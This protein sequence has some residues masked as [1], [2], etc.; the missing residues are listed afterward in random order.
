MRLLYRFQE[1]VSSVTS[2][3]ETITLEIQNS[4]PL[5]F[6]I[7]V[8]QVAQVVQALKGPGVSFDALCGLL[9]GQSDLQKAAQLVTYYLERFAKASLIEWTVVDEQGELARVKSLAK[10]YMPRMDLA[11]AGS[12][13][14]CRFAYLHRIDDL[15][16]LES[17]LARGRVVI[18]ERGM[19]ALLNIMHA[20]QAK[21]EE[22]L[23]VMLWRF[24]FFDEVNAPESEAKRCWE[25]QDLLLHEASRLNRDVQPVGGTY[26]FEGVFPAPPGIKPAMQ[27][28]LIKLPEPDPVAIESRCGSLHEL[29]ERRLSTRTFDE[30]DFSLKALSE[31]LWRV[32]RTKKIIPSEK[33]ELIARTYPAG[34]SVN[35]LEFYLAIERCEGLAPG[36]YH[37]AG[38]TH[39]LTAIADSA[40]AAQKIITRSC[41][42]MGLAQDAV[43]PNLTIVLTTRLPRVA[44]KYQGMAY[45]VTLLHVGV[46]MELMYLVATD[47]N[48]AACANGSGDSRLF[49]Q[50]TGISPFEETSVGEFCLGII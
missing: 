5:I 36:L 32:C 40:G 11:P 48:L 37:Y 29:Q 20:A 18:T 15:L 22:P 28:K 30:Q 25:F 41:H 16:V 7:G 43:R 2:Q 31:F 45:R 39:A 12:L 49:E 9:S 38:L 21:R 50:A 34:G 23:S 14:L 35:E 42:A 1:R 26:R 17:S 6:R 46:V 47:M 3:G 19:P 10:G 8:A 44:W 13:A 4:P 27:G 33:Q 24:G